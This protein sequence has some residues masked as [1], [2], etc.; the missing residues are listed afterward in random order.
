MLVSTKQLSHQLM[1]SLDTSY[2]NFINSQFES[3]NRHWEEI[4]DKV[5]DNIFRVHRALTSKTCIKKEE[6]NFKL[7]ERVGK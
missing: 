2:E 6:K 3:C 1:G 5:L 4:L 7:A